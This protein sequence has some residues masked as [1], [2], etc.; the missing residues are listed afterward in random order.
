MDLGKIFLA[1]A[2]KRLQ[3]YKELGDKTLNVLNEVDFHFTPSEECN[4][5]AVIIQHMHGNMLSRWTNFLTADGE[6]QWRKRDA[7]FE[8]QNLNRHQLIDLWEV[9]WKCFLD[10]LHSL[11]VNDLEKNI[12]IRSESISVIDAINRQLTHYPYHVGQIILIARLIKKQEWQSLSIPRGA[13]SAFNNHM[14]NKS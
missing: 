12:T 1:S 14:K 8:D 4:S 2:I 10:E 7:E 11:S 5:I 13:S 6:K 3:Y 9:G